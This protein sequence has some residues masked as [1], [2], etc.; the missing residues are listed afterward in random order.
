MPDERKHWLREGTVLDGKYEICRVIGQGGFGITYEGIHRRISL[1]VAVKELFIRGC[2][3]RDCTK[4]SEVEVPEEYR[5]VFGRQK[6]KFLGE[7]RTLSEFAQDPGIVQVMDYFEA[8]GTAYIV[9]EYLDGITLKEFIKERGRMP[10]EEIFSRMLPIV[11]ALGQIHARGIILRDISPDNIMV[12]EDGSFRLMDFGAARAYKNK[13]GRGMSVILKDGYAPPEQYRAGAAQGPW[14]DIYALC[15]VMYECACGKAPQM[16]AAR[17]LKDSCGLPSS[18]GA[19][20]TGKQEEILMRGLAVDPAGR[21]QRMEE[22]EAAIRDCLGQETEGSGRRKENGSLQERELPQTED[23]SSGRRTGRRRSKKLITAAVCA[24]LLL[25]AAALGVWQRYRGTAEYRMAHMPAYQAVL[26]PSGELSAKEFYEMGTI[27]EE[28]LSRVAG[29]GSYLLTEGKGVFAVTIPEDLFPSA[30]IPDY[31]E[32]YVW[33]NYMWYLFPYTGGTDGIWGVQNVSDENEGVP[34]I[35][36]ADM[37]EEAQVERGEDGYNLKITIARQYAGEVFDGLPERCLLCKDL[38][39]GYLWSGEEVFSYGAVTASA[40]ERCLYVTDGQQEGKYLDTLAYNMSN[41]GLP[42]RLDVLAEPRTVWEE[43]SEAVH[44]GTYQ[45]G[46]EEL[47]GEETAVLLYA[48]EEYSST[49]EADWNSTVIDFKRRLDVLEAP[50][51][52]GYSEKEERDLVV[53]IPA[54]EMNEL[55]AVLLAK[56]TSFFGV[57]DSWGIRWELSD[58]NWERIEAEEAS[59]DAW[60]SLTLQCAPDM[61]ESWEEL[62]KEYADDGEDTLYLWAGECRLA[63]CEIDEECRNGTVVFREPLITE[64]VD[65]GKLYEYI[66]VLTSE[67]AMTCYYV[68]DETVML[69]AEGRPDSWSELEGEEEWLETPDFTA[70]VAAIRSVDPRAAVEAAYGVNESSMDIYLSME[71]TE[72]GLGELLGTV[73]EIYE[74]CNFDDGTVGEVNFCVK[75][76]EEDITITL[77]KK[78]MERR[79]VVWTFAVGETGSRYVETMDA[80][81]EEDPFWKEHLEQ[82]SEYDF[83]IYS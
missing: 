49:G 53:K 54:E 17:V 20:I 44:P 73:Q 74:T 25:A 9:M 34:V 70:Y 5:E 77:D 33:G 40:Q 2:L 64:G 31:G 48:Y 24:V 45:C 41:A 80:M 67:T 79:M 62:L 10:G 13:A 14:T 39:F 58:Y 18:M 56:T 72:D 28:R 60:G 32:A 26:T 65:A 42:S 46:E 8:N 51:A 3:Y 36:T 75:A 22:L 59:E 1:R 78:R 52:F 16:S 19:R 63:A 61:L 81:M 23:Q 11:R 68:L 47:E 37:I 30:E 4:S 27:L 12:L 43:V 66:R 76:G 55:Y 83:R 82:E 50:Y 35:L 29:E 69:D 15:A 57:G 6:G 38:M 21:F 7:A 71:A